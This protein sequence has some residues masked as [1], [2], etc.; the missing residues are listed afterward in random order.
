[1]WNFNWLE[2]LWG[3]PTVHNIDADIVMTDFHGVNPMFSNV[4]S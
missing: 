4:L 2:I 3:I 1:M